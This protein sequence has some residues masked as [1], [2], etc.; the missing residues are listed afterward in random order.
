MLPDCVALAVSGLVIARRMAARGASSF[1]CTVLPSL[2]MPS[3]FHIA[4]RS[5]GIG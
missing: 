3:C 4:E 5:T 2:S 1:K